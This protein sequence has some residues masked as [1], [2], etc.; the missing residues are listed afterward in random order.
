MAIPAVTESWTGVVNE[1]TIGATK[2]QGGTR[3]STVTVGG[4][5][6]LPFH[7]FEGECGKKP[8][9]AAHI[10]SV[11]PEEWTDE[12]K[13][14]YSSVS[15]E[16]GKW[17][18]YCMDELNVDL[19]CLS[20]EACHPDKGNMDENHAVDT[21][22]SIV[23]SVGLPLIIWGCGFPEKDNQIMPKV[24]AALKGERVLLGSATQ[25]N[26]K[27]IAAVALADNHNLIA[28]APLDINI[29]KQV[30]ILLSDMDFPLERVVM[31]QTTGALGYGLEYVY[32]IQE[33]ERLAALNGDKMMAMPMLATVGHES[34]RAKEAKAPSSEFPAW[35][36]E[37]KRGPLW[38][39]I[40]GM[41]MLVSGVD[42]LL[43]RHPEAI[44]SIRKAID[45]LY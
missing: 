18:K 9:I 29:G 33:R 32:S 6:T 27:T 35:G 43:M 22:K 23:N 26:Y 37:K 41:A 44:K 25:H 11:L 13:Q 14:Q 39:L 15:D 24:S 4:A 31:F 1:V 21:V 19:I 20:L 7:Q 28:E 42:I 12:L 38:E 8:V 45:R 16:P 3:T 2:E 34:W 40:T 10:L 30:N 17:A 36:D 5:K